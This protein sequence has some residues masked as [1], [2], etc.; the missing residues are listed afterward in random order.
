[1]ELIAVRSAVK[2]RDTARDFLRYCDPS[3]PA[4]LMT[5]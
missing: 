2:G 5:G 1:M 4:A 3:K